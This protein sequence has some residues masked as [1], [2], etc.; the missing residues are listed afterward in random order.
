MPSSRESSWPRGQTHVSHV[1][2]MAGIFFTTSATWEASI[3]SN[4]SFKLFLS[5]HAQKELR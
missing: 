5:F 1:Y 3:V 2:C 4:Q